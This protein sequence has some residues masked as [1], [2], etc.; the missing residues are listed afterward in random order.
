[1][2]NA[3]FSTNLVLAA[4]AFITV[5]IDGIDIKSK[6]GSCFC[7]S[8]GARGGGRQEVKRLNSVILSL[9]DYF[10]NT[11]EMLGMKLSVLETSI[12]YQRHQM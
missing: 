5:D 10:N 8:T 3:T 2:G 9:A 11:C 4:M 12:V 1:M 7:G 6:C